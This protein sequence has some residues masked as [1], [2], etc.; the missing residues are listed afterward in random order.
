MSNERYPTVCEICDERFVLG[1]EQAEMFDPNQPAA[2][3]VI[4]HVECGLHR[5]MEIA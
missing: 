2:D 5:G 1:D 3:N 4:C